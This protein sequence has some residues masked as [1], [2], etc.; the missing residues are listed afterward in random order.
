M[1]GLALAVGGMAVFA[2]EYPTTWVWIVCSVA[3]LGG[4]AAIGGLLK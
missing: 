3:F 2:N 4:A 1:S